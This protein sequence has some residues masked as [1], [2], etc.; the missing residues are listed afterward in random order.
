MMKKFLWLCY[1]LGA[2]AFVVPPQ[3]V[4]QWKQTSGPMAG[5]TLASV[6]AVYV[7]GDALFA[8]TQTG[9]VFRSMDKGDTWQAVNSGLPSVAV[10]SFAMSGKKLYAGIENGGNA[11]GG[12]VYQSADSGTSWKQAAG[13]PLNCPINAMAV[14]DSILYA[15]S[16]NAKLFRLAS[17]GLKWTDITVG[18]PNDQI[19]GINING[20]DVYAATYRSGV[21][22]STDH[23][24]TWML[25]APVIAGKSLQTIAFIDT[26][27]FG[28]F[29]GGIYRLNASRT[30]WKEITKG[31]TSS[32]VTSF[33]TVG[34][35]LIAGTTG[36]VFLSTDLGENWIDTGLKGISIYSLAVSGTDLFAGSNNNGVWRRPIIDFTNG[37]ILAVEKIERPIVGSYALK[38]NYPNPFNPSTTISFSLPVRSFVT[39]K[40]LNVMGREVAT[41]AKEALSAGRYSRTW[42]AGALS[43][44]IY[45]YR[46]QA[47]AYAE[48]KRLVLL[49]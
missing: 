12:G 8:G 43:S 10:F 49:R 30:A 46:L 2:L 14:T 13:T 47:G 38:Q 44:G 7:T 17:D 28:G 19:V 31:L 16:W 33:C 32:G 26:N 5:S 22:R 45:F 36:S 3:S 24:Q 21:W 23:G 39:L 37:S 40:I 11:S 34:S 41:L 27:M 1:T 18:L 4:S 25:A 29:L 6:R 15:G 35:M 9:G 20:T 48:T 42:N